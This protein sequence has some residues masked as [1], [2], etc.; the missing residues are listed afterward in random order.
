MAFDIAVKRVYG[1]PE[2]TD[3]QRVLVDRVWPRGVAKMDAALTLW[4]K[5]IAPS[6]ALR[7]W[8]GHE[9]ERWAEFQKRYHAE[10]DRNEEAVAQLR[11]LLREGK[12]TLLYGAHDE[13]H[14][15]A[16]ALAGYLRQ[17]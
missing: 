6:D 4:L 2:K 1:T 14:N 13:A 12:V 16:V 15:N 17:A 5:E 7:K 11:G 10:L 8:F 3:G 9:P